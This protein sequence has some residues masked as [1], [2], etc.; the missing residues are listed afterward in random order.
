[1]QAA[2]QPDTAADSTLE[3]IERV[4][5]KMLAVQHSPVLA[6]SKDS[7]ALPAQAPILAVSDHLVDSATK[8]PLDSAI[9]YEENGF[10]GWTMR[11]KLPLHPPPG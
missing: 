9:D 8:E 10:L 7:I 11:G 1:M 4:L 5:D 6:T 3:H 2:R